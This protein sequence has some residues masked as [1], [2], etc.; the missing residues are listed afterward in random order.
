MAKLKEFKRLS[1]PPAADDPDFQKKLARWLRDTVDQLYQRETDI[2]SIVNGQIEFPATPDRSSS[3][4]GPNIRCSFRTFN[5][6]QPA[7]KPA[8]KG[9]TA[10]VE[11]AHGLDR[12]P[13]GWFVAQPQTPGVVLDQILCNYLEAP[14]VPGYTS[15][16]VT[17]ARTITGAPAIAGGWVNN[18][19]FGGDQI[20]VSANIAGVATANNAVGSDIVTRPAGDW[21]TE[22]RLGWWFRFTAGTED[23]WHQ[24][25]LIDGKDPKRMRVRPIFQQA[26]VAGAYEIRA[27]D[28][29]WRNIK[30]VNAG[31]PNTLTLVANKPGTEV[32]VGTT[33]CEYV[34]RRPANERTLWLRVMQQSP[35]MVVLTLC[36]F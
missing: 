22:E 16:T 4:S 32:P 36:I 24:V 7:K 25:T 27:W 33:G 17:A 20:M 1:L 2:D 18:Q 21:N 30:T 14:F 26:H 34:I 35:E 19:V 15:V 9:V 10:V 29:Q 12:V 11:I 6:A 5:L 3:T 23:N 31:A 28:Q 13:R 8:K